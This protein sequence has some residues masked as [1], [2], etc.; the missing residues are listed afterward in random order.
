MMLKIFSKL[1]VIGIDIWGLIS[2]IKLIV[3]NIELWTA[4]SANDKSIIGLVK[5]LGITAFFGLLSMIFLAMLTGLYY[6]Y[7]HKK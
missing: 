2:I 6:N 4:W 1:M 3:H 5:L 7:V